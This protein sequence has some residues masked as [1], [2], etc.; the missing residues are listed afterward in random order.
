M[1]RLRSTKAWIARHKKLSVVL[2]LVLAAI[3]WVATPYPRGMLMAQLDYLRGHLEV[4]TYGYPV[5][6]RRRYGQILQER[7]GVH[8]NT[9]AGCCISPWLQAYVAGYNDVAE[10]HLREMFGRDVLGECAELLARSG[11]GG[12]GPLAR[13]SGD[14]DTA[15]AA[16][17]GVAAEDAWSTRRTPR[18]PRDHVR[19]SSVA[20]LVTIQRLTNCLS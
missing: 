5:R 18:L 15:I 10:A 12:R 14:R 8:L 16:F 1:P 6:W 3:L 9:V 7:Y 19:V 20:S 2:A 17:A 13:H 11:N 4:K